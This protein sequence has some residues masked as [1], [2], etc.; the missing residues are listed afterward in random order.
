MEIMIQRISEI[1]NQ[2][3]RMLAMIRNHENFLDN[4][5]EEL[6]KLQSQ[7]NQ[8]IRT[9]APRSSYELLGDLHKKPIEM[10]TLSSGLSGATTLNHSKLINQNS[11][12][13]TTSQVI[14]FP[15]EMTEAYKNIMKFFT[16]K[17]SQTV[18]RTIK[19]TKYPR[20]ICSEDCSPDVVQKLFR[21]GFLDKVMTD[22]SL[23]SVSKLPSII[24]RS[25]DELGLRFGRGIFCVQIFDAAMDLEGKPIIIAQIFKTGRNTKIDV[26]NSDHQWDIP[27]KVENF[28]SWLGEKRAHGIHTIKCRLEDYIRNKKVAII[29]RSNHGEVEEMI[30]INYLMEMGDETSQQILIEMHTK[31]MDKKYKHSSETLAHYESIYGPRKSCLI[32]IEPIRPEPMNIDSIRPK[33]EAHPGKEEDPFV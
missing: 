4:L 13:I 11:S 1:R 24:P 3:R 14:Q 26:D 17:K 18:Y 5:E 6:K 23:N 25:I 20:Y 29:A 28:K 19:M 27:C 30:T 12:E 8:N 2:N 21:Y 16:Y 10:P 33:E 22:E 9:I 31:L 7:N 15:P 32:R